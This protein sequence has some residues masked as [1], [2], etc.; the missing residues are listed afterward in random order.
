MLKKSFDYQYKLFLA[1]S[2]IK[3]LSG[4]GQGRKFNL[5]HNEREI[6]VIFQNKIK[7]LSIANYRNIPN[8]TKSID[9]IKRTLDQSE[10][11]RSIFGSPW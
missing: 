11:K 10:N 1:I 5:Q 7:Y 9:I 4:K 8:S 3:Y 2:T 6:S